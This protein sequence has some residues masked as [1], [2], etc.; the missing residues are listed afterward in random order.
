MQHF[1]F[2]PWTAIIALV[3]VISSAAIL[4]TSPTQELSA[5]TEKVLSVSVIDVLPQVFTPS[6]QAFGKIE[7]PHL[8]SLTAQVEGEI[9]YI[10]K[11]FIEGAHLLKGEIIYQIDGSD[12]R[13]KLKQRN[14]EL[15]IAQA[16]LQLELGEQKVAER[17]YQQIS[18]DFSGENII[19]QKSLMLRQPQLETA[20][21]N[22]TIAQSNV[23]LAKKNLQRCVVVSSE[24]YTVL[25]KTIYQGSFVNK[26]DNLGELA[27]LSILRV[28]LAVPRD[29]ATVLSINQV[30]NISA[31]SNNSHQAL[32]S[33]LSPNL[34]DNSQLQQVYLSIINPEKPFILGEFITADLTLT[35]QKNTLKI[36][37]SAI[38]DSVFWVVNEDNKLSA[39]AAKIIW[40]NESYAIINNN[41]AKGESIVTSAIAGAQEGM[42]ANIV[43]G[44]L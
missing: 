33:Q 30:V 10:N 13:H 25:T 12:Y 4:A 22:V 35:P 17:E 14:S 20:K 36:P 31:E 34:H 16:N 6:Y 2:K 5:Q 8:L 7:S 9:T 44:V 3:A 11:A 37:L 41:I 42:L 23:N 43:T 24:N 40:Q 15:K 29:I 32:V 28:S 18:A 19:L 27:Q 39:K 26:G 1:I 38:D 21:A